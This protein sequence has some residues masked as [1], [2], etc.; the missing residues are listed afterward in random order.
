MS[1]EEFLSRFDDTLKKEDLNAPIGENGAEPLQ[2]NIEGT[3]EGMLRRSNCA[4]SRK[5]ANYWWNPMIAELRAQTHKAL[6]KVT[7]D[8][9]K[10]A[11]N[12]DPSSTP[13]RRSEGS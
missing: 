11:G 5:Y 13:T 3:C 9:K 2:K 12:T 1:P 10:N 4:A 8:R 6:R 7:R